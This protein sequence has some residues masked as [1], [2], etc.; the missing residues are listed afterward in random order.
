MK[1]CLL[2]GAAGHPNFGDE[3]IMRVW[4]NNYLDLFQGG[5]VFCDGWGAELKRCIEVMHVDKVYAVS[6][7]Q[8]IFKTSRHFRIEDNKISIIDIDNYKNDIKAIAQNLKEFGI[9]AIHLFGGGYINSMW[10]RAYILILSS[11]LVA[12]EAKI[13][14]FATGLGLLPCDP[15]YYNFVKL[16]KHFSLCDVRDKESFS[17]LSM[18][19][20]FNISYSGDDVLM[21][22]DREKNYLVKEEDEP[23]LVI[24]LQNDLFHGDALLPKILSEDLLLHFANNGIRNLKLIAAMEPDSRIKM[25]ETMDRMHSYGLTVSYVDHFTLLEHGIPVHKDSF[26]ITSRYHVH[27]IASLWGCRGIALSSNKYYDVK[28]ASV[29]MMGSAWDVV[30]FTDAERMF[31]NSEEVLAKVRNALSHH[32]DIKSHFID[33]KAFILDRVIKQIKNCKYVNLD[34]DMAF[35]L[36]KVIN[37]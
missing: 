13:P 25:K 28:H 20:S 36:I 19:N 22:F 4:I 12:C 30:N 33:K 5:M 21:A 14:V 26:F 7:V 1:S 17:L 31:S 8:S 23:S 18:C 35:D 27:L 24:C 15:A 32:A 37:N 11:L 10:S 6:D 9:E 16:F 29:N 2:V 3:A 34:L